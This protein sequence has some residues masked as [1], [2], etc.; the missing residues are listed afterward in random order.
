M[1]AIDL[2]EYGGP[3]KMQVADLPTPIPA[4][5]EVL[6][7]ISAAGVNRPDIVQRNGLY[8]APAG[9]SSIL[10][11]EVAGEVVAVG[12]EVK[13]WKLGDKVCALTNGGGYAEFVAVPEGQCLPIPAGLTEVEAAALPETFFTV[14]SNVFDRAKLQSGEILLVHGG[15]SGIGTTAIQLAHHLGS[16]VFATAGSTEKCEA[17]E[18]LGAERAINYHEEDFVAVVRE[19]T[20]G[21][22]ADV[23]LDMVGGEYIERNIRMAAHDGR[24]VNIAF[25]KGSKVEVNMLPVMLKRLTLTGS[26]L[27]ARTAEVK[28]DIA[29]SLETKVWPLIEAEKI[30][31]QIAAQF[32]LE[33]VAEAHRLLESGKVIGKIVLTL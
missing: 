14:W 11:L 13:R 9:A 21:H 29:Y 3:E 6:V 31:P 12:D 8:P 28:A 25:L 32:P 30:R 1:R 27:R 15:S 33:Q 23:I 17:C 22:G 18:R 2:P 26:T 10:G 16:R 5:D 7:K 4:A 19:A 20:A 24:I